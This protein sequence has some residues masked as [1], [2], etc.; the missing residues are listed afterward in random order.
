MATIKIKTMGGGGSE[1]TFENLDLKITVGQFKDLIETRLS[2]PKATQRLIFSGRVLTDDQTLEAAGLN[3]GVQV[4]LVSIQARAAPAAPATPVAQPPNLFGGGSTN[5]AGAGGSAGG[6]MPDMSGPEMEYV[7]RILQTPQGQ[8]MFQALMQNPEALQ[9][10]PQV[11]NNPEIAAM[12]QHLVQNP[13]ALAQLMQG[14]APQ[15]PRRVVPREIFNVAMDVLNGAAIPPEYDMRNNSPSGRS[16][17]SAGAQASTGSTTTGGQEFVSRDQINAALDACILMLPQ[18][19]GA[20]P[21]AMNTE[22]PASDVATQASAET[23]PDP[24]SVMDVDTTTPAANTESGS[25]SDPTSTSPAASQYSAQLE[26]L[27]QMGFTNDAQCLQA[28][29]AAGG[30][31]MTAV[32]FL[33]EM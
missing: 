25:T 19:P 32:A 16:Q 15:Q 1:Q 14:N 11:R 30:E 18:Q 3:D 17:P 29:E 33:T 8:A 20:G 6:S 22:E 5:A 24:D 31:V 7:A 26:Q 12:L 23:L 27:H 21:V 9:Q 10:I 13:Q 2:T 28:L 4:H